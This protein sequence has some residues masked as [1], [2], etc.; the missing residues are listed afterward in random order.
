MARHM[1]SL[2]LQSLMLWMSRYVATIADP[3]IKVADMY[4]I[5]LTLHRRKSSTSLIFV[6]G[7]TYLSPRDE[8][9]TNCDVLQHGPVCVGHT[10]SVLG[11]C[12]IG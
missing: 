12:T 11:C 6:A 5:E 7:N 3:A 2:V 10:P 4:K 1:G 8:R 9:T